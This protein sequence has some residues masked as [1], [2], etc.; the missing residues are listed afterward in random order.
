VT[1]LLG[2][3]QGLLS[4]FKH[5]LYIHVLTFLTFLKKIFFNV[6]YIYGVNVAGL[7]ICIFTA[8]QFKF[9]IFKGLY[10]VKTRICSMAIF[11]ILTPFW[12]SVTAILGI[13]GHPR[14]WV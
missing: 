2:S 11:D 12:H 6:L 1:L 4:R 8:K 13:G 5:F 3:D 9:A 10:A 7:S 14:N